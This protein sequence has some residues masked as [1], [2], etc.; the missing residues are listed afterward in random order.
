[1]TRRLTALGLA[2]MIAGCSATKTLEELEA[3]ALRSGD[4]SLVEEREAVIAKREAR[5]ASQCPDGT[6]SYCATSI[7]SHRCQCVAKAAML[8]F[9]VAR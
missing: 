2:L 6:V 9:L 1:M 8:D 5:R 7:G 3:D 4:W